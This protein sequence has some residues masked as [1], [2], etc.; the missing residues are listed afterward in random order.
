[1]RIIQE[2]RR[3]CLSLLE[4]VSACD[5]LKAT[6]RIATSGEHNV[7]DVSVG[8]ENWVTKIS[9][10]VQDGVKGKKPEKDQGECWNNQ[11]TSTIKRTYEQT[12]IVML[13][14]RNTWRE[15]KL[16]QKTK[17]FWIND[18]SSPKNNSIFRINDTSSPK[19]NSIWN[20]PSLALSAE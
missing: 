20:S 9:S 16:F 4:K 15:T 7:R 18:T 1:M 3:T 5:C 10:V 19:N 17:L 2:N 6:L 8:C 12:W 11:V 14:H 13:N